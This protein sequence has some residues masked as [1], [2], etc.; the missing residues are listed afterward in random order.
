[1][2][3][4]AAFIIILIKSSD[5]FCMIGCSDSALKDQEVVAEMDC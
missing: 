5:D 1:M 4:F 2:S 3:A